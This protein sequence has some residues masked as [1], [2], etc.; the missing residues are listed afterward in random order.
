MYKLKVLIFI[1]VCWFACKP[2]VSQ[3]NLVTNDSAHVVAAELI[4]PDSSIA[5]KFINT[6][7]E[8]LEGEAVELSEWVN[9]NPL[10]T[11]TFKDELHALVTQATDLEGNG[12]DYDPIL[13]AQDYPE[14]GFELKS[15][16]H[17]TGYLTVNGKK[18]KEFTVTLKLIKADNTWLVDGAGVINIPENQ[19]I[20]K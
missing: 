2:K 20:P 14:E 3:E 16:D 18:W 4:N 7:I 8:N 9:N 12:L 17:E 6:Y 19:R 11:Q 1:A 13:N 10:V 15:I 5:L